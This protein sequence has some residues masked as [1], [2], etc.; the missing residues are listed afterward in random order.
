V[1]DHFD[2]MVIKPVHPNLGFKYMFA[3][4]LS[5]SEQDKL[6][7]QILAKP[8]LYVGQQRTPMSTVPVLTP[9]GLKPRH[10][11]MRSFLVAGEHD[12]MTMP[13]GLTRVSP[14][15]NAL[16][17]SN[18]AGGISKDTWVLAT[19][20]EKFVSLLSE[21]RQARLA[22]DR[23]G[24]VPGRVA[25]NMFWVGRYAERA[26][27]SS[28]LLR[29]VLQFIETGESDETPAF[30]QLLTTLTGLKNPV[31]PVEGCSE[32]IALQSDVEDAINGKLNINSQVRILMSLLRSV[33]SVRDRLSVDT[34]R[35]I[36][37]ID[38]QL[39]SLNRTQPHILSSSLD[40]E[41]NLITA[42]TAFN[43]LTQEH[44]TQ[45]RSWRFLDI[46]RRIERSLQI[47][48][49][50]RATLINNSEDNELILLS[51]SLLSIADCLMTYRRRYR[52]G[53]KVPALLELMLY[54]ENNPRSLANQVARI[55]QNVGHLPKQGN[56]DSRTELERLALETSTLIRLADI[57]RLAT[58]TS[59]TNHR[60]K[61]ENFLAITQ[62][63]LHSLSELL[64][65]TY[66]RAGEQPHQLLSL[67]TRK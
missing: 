10:T 56:T 13:G 46:G 36:K 27:Y 53:I 51:D 61:L 31:P 62:S 60:D 39:T 63:R 58:V 19:E 3:S 17:V 41:E 11:V 44:I 33:R 9:D 54:D 7:Q 16:I 45:G 43:G 18:Q 5:Q 23:G 55:E 67:Q 25:D 59:D 48:R 15:D 34:W 57:N 20:P 24:E 66:F 1:L 2:D 12:Y 35:I 42:L 28:R 37:I 30:R 50:L 4:R 65:E 38:E 40:A 8:H 52:F 47:I 26:E 29:L 22:P 32:F 14:Q 21:R 64:T 49:L 6:R